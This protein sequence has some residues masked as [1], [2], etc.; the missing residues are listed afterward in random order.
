MTPKR[1]KERWKHIQNIK[2]HKRKVHFS[3][4]EAAWQSIWERS[5]F[6]DAP[7]QPMHAY[8]CPVCGKYVTGRANKQQS[9]EFVQETLT[10]MAERRKL[11]GQ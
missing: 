4:P 5:E 1:G 9:V 6:G 10:R 11:G 7:R 3:T 2:N 8:R